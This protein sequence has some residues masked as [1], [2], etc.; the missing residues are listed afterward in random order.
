MYRAKE[1][2]R[3]RH[4][5]FDQQMHTQAVAYLELETGLRRA[6]ERNELRLFYQPIV[7]LET[8]DLVSFEALLRWKHP[9]RGLLYPADFLTAAEETGLIIPIGWWVFDEACRQICAWRELMGD[10]MCIPVHVNLS[11]RQLEQ[12][13]LV[14]RWMRSSTNGRFRRGVCTWS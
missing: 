2:G 6:L 7:D 8:Q 12:R 10:E 3:S 1:L 5:V 11:G 14:D 4:E 9:E 13:D